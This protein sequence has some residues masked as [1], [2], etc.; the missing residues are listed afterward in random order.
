[1]L[2]HSAQTVID[3]PMCDDAAVAVAVDFD[4]VD[5]VL[6]QATIPTVSMTPAADKRPKCFGWFIR[7]LL[8]SSLRTQVSGESRPLRAQPTVRHL[9]SP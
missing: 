2:V 7:R 3:P 4:D 8:T 1:V 9:P 6:P 5:D